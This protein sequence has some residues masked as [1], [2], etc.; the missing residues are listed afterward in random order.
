[1]ARR[2]RT[3]AS[4]NKTR[5]KEPEEKQVRASNLRAYLPLAIL[6]IIVLVGTF[7]RVYHLNYPVIGYHNWKETH[8]ITEARNFAEHG[9]FT[10]GFFVPYSDLPFL[11]SD[12]SGAH[13]DTFP[14]ISIIVGIAF[15]ILGPSLA[16]AR[17][18]NMLLGIGAIIAM[19]FFMKKL[20]KRE[21]I[22]LLCAFL[23]AINPLFIY[24]SHNVQLDNTGL[25]FMLLSL[26]FYLE[27]IEKN[28][29]RNAMY[30]A[31][32][33]ALGILTKYSFAIFIIP[34]LFIFPWKRLKEIRTRWKTYLFSALILFLIPVW[35]VYSNIIL[36]KTLNVPIEGNLIYANLSAAFSADTWTALKIYALDNYG[37]IGN[38]Q[39]GIV[40]A[41]LG[42]IVFLLMLRKQGM[43]T[44]NKF[45]LGYILGLIPWFIVMAEK[46]AGHSYHQYPIAPLI[47]M[48][49][50]YLFVIISVNVESLIG[51]AHLR[52]IPLVIFALLLLPS[53]ITA[54]DRV[55]DRQFIGLDVAGEYIKAHSQPTETIFHSS[56]QNYGV[57]WNADR[58][59]YRPPATVE[60]LMWGEENRNVR[61]IFMYQ[62]GISQYMS[63]SEVAGYISE[64]YALRQVGLMQQGAQFTPI[65]LLLEKGG[66]TNFSDLNGYLQNKQPQTR[67]YETTKGKTQMTYIDVD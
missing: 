1:M 7:F 36:P 35:I 39:L 48:L 21:D 28:D 54:K 33:L 6:L 5:P 22:A 63:N 19:Y 38:F 18:I 30:T 51:K 37:G 58:K 15:K 32:A 34:M 43:K 46:L 4:Q 56:N 50:A 29:T 59:G 44:S 31:L 47:I 66:T 65:Y 9:F 23:V 57:L 49:I 42:L 8:Y 41:T 13:P 64:N 16:I 62:W 20:F 10:H 52:Y 17:I 2:K 61:W 26:I 24:F 60:D 3:S 53:S 67:E 55:F 40:L 25:F 11:R 14:T 27:W 45:L 12:E